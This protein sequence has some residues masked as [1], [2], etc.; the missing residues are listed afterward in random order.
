MLVNPRVLLSTAA[1]FDAWDGTDRGPIPSGPVSIIGRDGRNDLE[2]PAISLVPEIASVLDALGR[3]EATLVRMS[4]SGAT[5]F[6]LYRDPESLAAGARQIAAD[7]P[8][9][10]QLSG[11]LRP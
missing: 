5:C 2:L 1:V 8:H 4:G 11:R 9:W 7:Q 10:W 3:T 6:A